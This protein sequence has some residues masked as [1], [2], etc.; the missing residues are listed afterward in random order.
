MIPEISWSLWLDK[1]AS[2][3]RSLFSLEEAAEAAGGKVEAARAA[4]HRAVRDHKVARVGDGFYVVV[5]SEFRDQGAPPY[6]WVVDARF[7]RLGRPYYLGLLTAALYHGASHQK[8]METQV[9]TDRQMRPF[10]FGDRRVIPIYRKTWP[11]LDLLQERTSRTGPF[12]ISGP[13]LTLVDAVRYPRHAAGLDNIAT[14]IREMDKGVK[15]RLLARVCGQTGETPMLQRLGWMLR[16]FGRP[17]LAEVVLDR[18]KARRMDTVPLETGNDAL[19]P[20][21]P[22]F[23][24][25]VNYMPEPEA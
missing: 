9:V 5:P 23:H 1:R 4:M 21:D 10:R 17:K 15:A 19:G 25:R 14:L 13:E 3:G 7:A 16:R 12:R 2:K 20:I 24:V 11:T 18:L 8:P 6:E 22:E